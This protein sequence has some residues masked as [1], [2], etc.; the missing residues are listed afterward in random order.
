MFS[1]TSDK[2]SVN[3]NRFF[4]VRRYFLAVSFCLTFLAGMLMAFYLSVFL[5]TGR[6]S[7]PSAITSV[8][9]PEAGSGD[10]FSLY[11]QKNPDPPG[12][13][14]VPDSP[15]RPGLRQVEKG[16]AFN[17][18]R[19]SGTIFSTARK[20]AVFE[21][22]RTRKQIILREGE[23]LD[24]FT[25]VRIERKSVEL[26]ASQDAPSPA[27]R[28]ESP[29]QKTDLLP[30]QESGR[31]VKKLGPHH[32]EIARRVM[33]ENLKDPARFLSQVRLV[34]FLENGKSVGFLLAGLRKDGFLGEIGLEDGDIVTKING[35]S[36]SNTFTAITQFASLGDKDAVFIELSRNSQNIVLKYTIH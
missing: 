25:V 16:S 10:S 9:R 36:L 12:R 26:A 15:Q 3:L 23:S 30:A 29:E 2:P 20:I 8:P 28:D 33:L 1:R 31:F 17:S 4:K 5:M 32:Y 24:E 19:L 27:D 22:T 34:P 6:A 11:L 14:S 35:E 13:Q 21:D 18:Y 7:G